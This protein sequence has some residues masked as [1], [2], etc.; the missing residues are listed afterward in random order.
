M[1]LGRYRAAHA[2]LTLVE[3]LCVCLLLAVI[4]SGL[5]R[6]LTSAYASQAAI[7]GQNEMQKE[8]QLGADAV[9]DT[10]RGATAFTAG[11][12]EQFTVERTDPTTG[13]VLWTARYY[14]QEGTLKAD[15]TVPGRVYTGKVICRHVVAPT[16]S[17]PLFRYQRL[18]RDPMTSLASVAEYA[19][20]Q[21]STSA[22][23]LALAVVSD[24]DRATETT[25]VMLRNRPPL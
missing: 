5:S 22:L 4:M 21:P 12:Y 14:Y 20:A 17:A 3:M 8:A 1:A 6:L 25:T 10:V 7:Q 24:Q 11:D 19:T 15:S 18:E 13:D 23:R 16:A 9:A 2:G